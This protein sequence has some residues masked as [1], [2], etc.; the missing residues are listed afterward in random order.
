LYVTTRG[1]KTGRSREIEI[2][3]TER[4]GRFYVI[5]E[6]ST[7]HWLQNLRKTPD[8]TLRVAGQTFAARARVVSPESEAELLRSVQE[9]SQSKYGWGDGTIV[10]LEPRVKE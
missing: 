3:F 2:W 4:A 6:Y 9:L 10:E 7:A 5:A 8:V 1:R